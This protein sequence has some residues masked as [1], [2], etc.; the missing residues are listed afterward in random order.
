MAAV[1]LDTA[2]RTARDYF[3]K[4]QTAIERKNFDY[5][6]EMFYQCLAAEPNFVKARQLLRALQVK[7]ASANPFKRLVSTAKAAPLLTK[8]KMTIPKDPL[9]AMTMCEQALSSDPRNP[10]ALLTL[11]EAAYTANFPETTVEVLEFYAKVNPRDPRALHYLGK[12]YRDCRQFEQARE[13]YDKLLEINP[14]DFEAQKAIK[15]CTADGAMHGGGWEAAKSYRDV[16]ADKEQATALEQESRVVR[17]EDMVE[18]L[19]KENLEKLA[20]NPNNPVVRRELG[21]LYA[22][23]Q[24][25]DTALRYLEAILQTEGADASLEREVSGI[26]TKQLEKRI[27]DKKTLLSHKPA[28]AAA[29][30][31]EI[32]QLEQQLNQVALVEAKRLVERYPNDLM[33]RYDLATLHMK[34]GEYQEA[35]NQFQRAVGQPQKRMAALNYL[36]QCFEKLGLHDLAIEQFTKAIDESPAMDMLK[37]DLIYNLGRAYE[38]MGD[39]E[40]AIIEFKKIAAVDFGYRDVKDRIMRKPAP[41]A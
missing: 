20:Q 11:A 41:K 5:A 13:T 2:N 28:N 9:E 27:E 39:A 30:E 21:K 15:D 23:K 16:I 6:I 25:F 40:K 33:Y 32:A 3:E 18:N 31:T 22:Q 19:I 8:A 24:D 14:N 34:A 37:K 29:L 17:A 1:T 36:G 35:I 38:V 4:A 26:K 7:Q 12:A 10:Q